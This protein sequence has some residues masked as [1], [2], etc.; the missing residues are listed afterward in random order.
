MT[1]AQLEKG[2]ALQQMIDEIKG[3][4]YLWNAATSLAGTKVVVMAENFIGPQDAGSPEF[5][6][7]EIKNMHVQFYKGR[8]RELETQ[9][10]AL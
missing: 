9:F 5:L 4:I 3:I 1:K 10:E 8:L 2:I 6:F 7:P